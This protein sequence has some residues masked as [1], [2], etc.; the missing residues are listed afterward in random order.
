[1]AVILGELF[2][3]KWYLPANIRLPVHWAL[4][5]RKCCDMKCAAEPAIE[6]WLVVK[7]AST[8]NTSGYVGSVAVRR[9]PALIFAFFKILPVF[10]LEPL[11]RFF[12]L[13][14]ILLVNEMST[15]AATSLHQVLGRI[16]EDAFAAIAIN[17]GPVGTQECCVDLPSLVAVGIRKT[18]PFM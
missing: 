13:R 7:D 3:P 17:A 2:Q 1:M 11:H 12:D 18:D 4:T 10:R 14:Q 5:G 15:V 16:V 6:S 9:K 8:V